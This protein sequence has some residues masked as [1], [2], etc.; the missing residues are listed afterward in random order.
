MTSQELKA[1]R[2]SLG[3]SQ[4]WLADQAGVQKR[5]VAYWESGRNQVPKDVAEIILSA[6]KD[7]AKKKVT[8]YPET[9]ARSIF[10]LQL[11]GL[12]K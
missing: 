3:L 9:F 8:D 1:L 7:A 6:A 4:Q 12:L 11:R 10:G 5:T 2:E